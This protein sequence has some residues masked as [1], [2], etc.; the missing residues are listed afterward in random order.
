MLRD[1]SPR[2]RPGTKFQ[3]RARRGFEAQAET[4]GFGNSRRAERGARAP[5]TYPGSSPWRTRALLPAQRA[6][7]ARQ[8]RGA[9]QLLPLLQPARVA[10]AAGSVYAATSFEVRAEEC[11]P[12]PPRQGRARSHR[13]V[14]E[15]LRSRGLHRAQQEQRAGAPKHPKLGLLPPC[16][17]FWELEDAAQRAG[18][19]PRLAQHQV[20]P[21]FLP[22][23]QP[24]LFFSRPH[25]PLLGEAAPR[26]HPCFAARCCTLRLS[27]LPAGF[28]C[29]FPRRQRSACKQLFLGLDTPGARSHHL[30]E[31]GCR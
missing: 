16:S 15:G 20:I 2:G 9:R 26:A 7:R 6:A 25:G 30:S 18:R 28:K 10:K 1:V 8:S 11:A 13:R 5:S 17:R 4:K 22:L 23:L 3:S 14:P 31:Q 24:L 12:V 27:E 21:S 19:T 29:G